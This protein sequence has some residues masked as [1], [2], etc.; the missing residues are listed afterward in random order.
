VNKKNLLLIFT[1]VFLT[2]INNIDF[3][4]AGENEQ[5]YIDQSLAIFAKN[6]SDKHNLKNF[7]KLESQSSNAKGDFSIALG[8]DNKSL[9]EFSFSSGKANLSSARF[10]QAHGRHN[11]AKGDFA[12]AYGD[13]T[14]AQAMYAYSFGALNISRGLYS[15]SFGKFNDAH[16][17]YAV[18]F[19]K[20][21][22][23]DEYSMALGKNNEVKAKN[24][25]A[26]GQENK[27]ANDFAYSLGKDNSIHGENS[28][29]IGDHI[30]LYNKNSFAIGSNINSSAANTV[31]IGVSPSKLYNNIANSL[32][33]GF[34]SDIP[35]LFVSSSYGDG[36]T[37]T[38]GIG[39]VDVSPIVK[40][41]VKGS[42]LIDDGNQKENFI[43]VSD[44]NGKGQW[45]DPKEMGF[46]M[47]SKKRKEEE[48][49]ISELNKKIKVN[50]EDEEDIEIGFDK[51]QRRPPSIFIDNDGMNN[52]SNVGVGTSQPQQKLHIAGAM[53]LEPQA[54]PPKNVSAGDIFYH[55]SGAFCGFIE[56][57]A[58]QGYWQKLAGNGYC[59]G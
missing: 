53:R 33:V 13:Y 8:E 56:E 39:T 26:F 50:D 57:V 23:A 42:V 10:S 24:S 21:N 47:S 11:E 38:V 7:K 52:S 49:K 30:E 3:S 51:S 59:E 55:R 5:K 16:G 36:L 20:N 37:G 48:K 14:T 17:D 25:F 6:K 46:L 22:F 15:Y 58:G 9:K 27:I 1:I 19:G 35:T 2:S 32:M 43:F 28:F 12:Y 31:T 29:A 44:E 41:H 54:F 45:K 34:N 4:G 18:S 40:L